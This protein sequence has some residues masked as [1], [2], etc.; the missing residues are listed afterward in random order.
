MTAV[1]L[2]RSGLVTGCLRTPGGAVETLPAP[3]AGCGALVGENGE[4]MGSVRDDSSPND[5]PVV[6]RRG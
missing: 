3:T 1:S 2:N 4:V 6:W 5:K